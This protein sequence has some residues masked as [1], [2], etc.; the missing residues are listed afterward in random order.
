L[1]RLRFR[2]ST[3]RTQSPASNY[4]QLADQLIRQRLSS[5]KL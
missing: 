4:L 1:F 3:P 5:Q 2:S